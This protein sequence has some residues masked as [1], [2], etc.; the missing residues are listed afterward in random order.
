MGHQFIFEFRVGDSNGADWQR[1]GAVTAV[2]GWQA[3]GCCGR[4][5]QATAHS[6][7]ERRH[8]HCLAAGPGD[9]SASHRQTRAWTRAVDQSLSGSLL[10]H[11]LKLTR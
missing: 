6:Q 4:L 1:R 9:T 7:P 5:C 2:K 11:A 10:D 3:L 8:I